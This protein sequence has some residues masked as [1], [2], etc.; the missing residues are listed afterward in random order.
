MR[1]Q[2][3]M[4]RIIETSVLVACLACSVCAR[5][6]VTYQSIVTT[7]EPTISGIPRQFEVASDLGAVYFANGDGVYS[8]N[9]EGSPELLVELG[10]QAL[11]VDAGVNYSSIVDFGVGDSG[12]IAFAARLIGDGVNV[13]NDFGIWAPRALGIPILHTTP[14][15]Y[16]HL[17]L[18]TTGIRCRSRWSP[19]H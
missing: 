6:E 3:C 4:Y 8:A 10:T 1:N 7:D 19:Y 15:S 11:G 18:P 12:E 2:N 14:V 16:T 5:A 13:T 17:T 9:G